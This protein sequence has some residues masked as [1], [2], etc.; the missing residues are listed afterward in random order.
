LATQVISRLRD[1][2]HVE[3][4]LLSLFE[5]PTLAEFAKRVEAA[6]GTDQLPGEPITRVPRDGELPLSFAQQRFWFLD[7]LRPGNPAYNSYAVMRLNGFLNIPAL[8]Q[9][10]NEVVR[11]HE[12]LR[13]S[14]PTVE[15]RPV[16]VILPKQPLTLTVADLSGLPKAKAEA[17][18]QRLGDAEAQHSFNLSDGPLIR[19]SLKRLDEQEHV[20]QITLHHIITDSWSNEVLYQEIGELYEGYVGGQPSHLPDLPLQYADYAAWQRRLAS[21]SPLRSHLSYWHHRLADAPR[22]PSLSPSTNPAPR[23]GAGRGRA[24]RFTLPASLAEALRALGRAHGATPYM[25]LLA[26]YVALLHLYTGEGE[27]VVGTPVAGRTRRETEGLIG[28]LINTVAV[29][30]S[31]GA[32]ASFVE[33]LGRVREAVLGAQEHAEVPFEA[34]EAEVRGGGRGGWPLFG[35]WFVVQQ[36]GA[37]QGWREWVGGLRV[38]REEVEVGWAQMEVAL[39]VSEEGEGGME[40]EMRYGVWAMGEEEAQEMC[41]HYVRVME[42]AV[43]SG[44]Q[45]DILDI[46]LIDLGA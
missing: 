34:V 46:D 45:V 17:E 39:M 5:A 13:T 43:S 8:E 2:L 12:A 37:G 35:A 6:S 14:F 4:P 28:C 15:G 41:E 16:Q 3:M 19:V 18:L 32:A 38:R 27:V 1:A 24:H 44:G 9:A 33:L 21:S 11:R 31:V 23:R 10:I 26:G 29:R 42:E 30:V 25:T 40:C 22:P 7:S 20:I 36:R